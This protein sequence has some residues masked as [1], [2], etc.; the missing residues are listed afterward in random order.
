MSASS[1]TRASSSSRVKKSWTG[2]PISEMCLCL[3]P[4]EFIGII[5]Y[6]IP[7][8]SCITSST[9]LKARLLVRDATLSTLSCHER[10]ILQVS[11]LFFI[12]EDKLFFDDFLSQ[13]DIRRTF[14]DVLVYPGLN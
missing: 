7:G 12:K 9:C 1:L 13:A 11:F 2:L 6:V 3:S 10:C 5:V 14:S 8:K 4:N